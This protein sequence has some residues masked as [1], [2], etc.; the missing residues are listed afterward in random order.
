VS[1]YGGFGGTGTRIDNG[2]QPAAVAVL[3]QIDVTPADQA[4][5]GDGKLELSHDL[6]G[7]GHAGVGTASRIDARLLLP[8]IDTMRPDGNS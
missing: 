6:S 2:G 8:T 4:S 3:N 7:I 5:T 1:C